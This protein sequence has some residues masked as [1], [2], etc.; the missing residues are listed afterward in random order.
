MV[1]LPE[2]W[3]SEPAEAELAGGLALELRREV[4][5]GHLLW[6]R[7]V[8]VVAKCRACDEVLV[9]LDGRERRPRRGS[10]RR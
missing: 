2:P 5:P 1:S 3:S 6:R 9:E 8:R 4:G 10:L 7:D